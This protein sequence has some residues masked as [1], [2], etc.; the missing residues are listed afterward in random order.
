MSIFDPDIFDPPPLT[1][2]EELVARHYL[3][4]QEKL[5]GPLTNEIDT[6]RNW[7]KLSAAS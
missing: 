6:G 2:T 5:H 7:S 3:A 1:E 4:Q